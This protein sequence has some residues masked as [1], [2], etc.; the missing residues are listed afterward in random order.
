MG[1]YINKTGLDQ[2]QACCK[3]VDD[4]VIKVVEIVALVK[5]VKKFF[6]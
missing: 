6:C 5:T 4:I 3:L 1:L 2:L